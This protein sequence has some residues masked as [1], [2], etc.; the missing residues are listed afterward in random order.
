MPVFG[1][2]PSSSS[3]QGGF[4]DTA[5][6]LRKDEVAVKKTDLQRL[7]AAAERE[8]QRITAEREHER[9][10]FDVVRALIG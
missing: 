3:A 5:P 10:K 1:G 7:Q 2:N 4:A 8:R 9:D 6:R